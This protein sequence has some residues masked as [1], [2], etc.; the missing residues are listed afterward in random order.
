MFCPNCGANA[1]NAKFCPECGTRIPVQDGASSAA[2]GTLTLRKYSSGRMREISADLYIDGDFRDVLGSSDSITVTLPA[3]E[4]ELLVHADGCVD[5]I[6][7]VHVD[8][9]ENRLCVLSV[10]D[11]GFISITQQGSLSR[12]VPPRAE[13]PA[14]SGTR[15]QAQ[16]YGASAAAFAYQEVELP[17]RCA[18]AEP[19][20]VSEPRKAEEDW[21]YGS[22]QAFTLPED[23]K[24]CKFCGSVIHRECVVCP[25]CGRQVERLKVEE[26]Q[27]IHQTYNS[28]NVYD[29]RT[30]VVAGGREK[31]K[32]ISFL[33]CL[34]FGWFGFHKFY[35]G[36]VGMGIL[37]LFTMGLFGIGVLIDLI[38]ILLK[39][40]PYYV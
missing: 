32:W 30:T 5:A 35:E 36:R 17:Q 38:A 31:N 6:Q 20:T 23:A 13:Q 26:P 25:E 16:A 19:L 10:D 22:R 1:G 11:A 14:G 33:L 28:Q 9:L 24:Y 40:N 8:P 34:M 18:E 29:H 37:Y 3:G 4:H 7:S 21:R 12:A 15:S 39:P 27:V 2:T